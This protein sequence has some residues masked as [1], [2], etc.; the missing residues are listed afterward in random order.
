[1]VE[2]PSEKDAWR[3][4]VVNSVTLPIIELAKRIMIRSGGW[5]GHT[6]FVIMKMDDF[7]VVLGMEILLEH[8]E[9]SIPLAKCLVITESTLTIV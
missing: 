2:P 1:M 8:Q 5:N 4:K 3:M 6:D 9:I 7:D